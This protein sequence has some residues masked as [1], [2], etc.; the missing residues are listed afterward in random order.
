M[1]H[2]RSVCPWVIQ[3][4]ND[5]KSLQAQLRHSNPKLAMLIYAQVVR[6]SQ[7]KSVSKMSTM[8][9]EHGFNWDVNVTCPVSEVA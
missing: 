5:P 2:P 9:S 7:K 6:D 3:A 8:L 4:G 1:F